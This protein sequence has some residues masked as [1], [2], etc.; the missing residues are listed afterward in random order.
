VAQTDSGS[1]IEPP[2]RQ[3]LSV[4]PL[5][6]YLLLQLCFTDD[7]WVVPYVAGGYSRYYYQLKVDQGDKVSGHQDGYH[8]RGGLKVL[9]DGLDPYFA[10]RAFQHWG[11]WNTYLSL[12]A[13]YAK[14]DDRGASDTN[15]GGVS[16]SA[17]I[18]IEF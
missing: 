18:V 12:E 3:T 7:Q 9:L 8:A 14:V 17:E 13:Q 6:S 1:P 4:V 2:T 16:Y 5:Q 11:I 15:L 10:E